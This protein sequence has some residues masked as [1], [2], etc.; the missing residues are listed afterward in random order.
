MAKNSGQIWVSNSWDIPNMDNCCQDK[1][2]HLLNMVPRTLL[3]NLAK[4]P[5]SNSSKCHPH[6]ILGEIILP[7]CHNVMQWSIEGGWVVD[8]VSICAG[9]ILTFKIW[10]DHENINTV[11]HGFIVFKPQI[12][13][14][15]YYFKNTT[16]ACCKKYFYFVY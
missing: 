8:I 10:P 15:C 6:H 2:W 5:I 1:S 9:R 13:P 3:W 11:C 14:D 7:P 4:N 16:H 12:T